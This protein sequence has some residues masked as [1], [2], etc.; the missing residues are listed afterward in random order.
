MIGSRA[1]L[2]VLRKHK[3]EFVFGLVGET[4][5]PLYAELDEFQEIKLISVR[6][7]RNSVIMADGYARTSYKPGVVEAPGVGASYL[8]PGLTEAYVS[9]IPLIVMYS[10]IPRY[11]EKRNYLTEYDK[12]LMFRTVSKEY[13]SVPNGSEIPRLM[14]RAFR[15]ATTGRTRPVV[16]RFPMDVYYEEVDEAEVYSQEEFSSF[17]SIRFTP[18]I[19][20]VRKAVKM[21]IQSERP[22]IICGQGV[23]LSRAW[24]EVFSLSQRL[25][26]PVGTTITG[27]GAYPEENELSIGVVGSRG[28]SDFSN[29]IVNKADLIFIIGSNTDSA[30]TSEWKVPKVDE[31][32]RIIQLDVSE[33]EIGNNYKT[34][35]SLLGDA[36]ATLSLINSMIGEGETKR[37]WRDYVVSRRAEHLNKVKEISE[38]KVSKVNPVKVIKVLEGYLGEAIITA[39]PGTGAIYSAAYFMT[40]RVGRRFI[41]NYSIG[42][43]GYALPAAIGAYFGT[44]GKIV[45]LTTDGNLPFVQGEL[46]TAKRVN[47]DVKVLVFTNNSFGWIRGAM[48][49][50]YGRVMKGTEINEIDYSKLASAYKIKY[51]LIERDSE[52]E[53]VIKRMLRDKEQYIIEVKVEAEDKLLPPVP[54]WKI[55]SEKY[56]IRYMG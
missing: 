32:K 13:I 22:V 16:V 41:Y 28:G 5:L 26:I 4:S 42:A 29:S 54:E 8:L 15:L 36:K 40:R 19:N 49:S 43:L 51:E 56:G 33:E 35:L 46:E 39:D 53:D 3:V 6:D 1:V 38:L 10:D 2:D 24:D 27:K 12:S 11:G 7:E 37:A 50:K 25:S 18:E 21:L 52:M 34:S 17:P 47:A 9:S 45:V 31:G 48:L 14:R 55:T 44:R 23:L 20:D 30:N